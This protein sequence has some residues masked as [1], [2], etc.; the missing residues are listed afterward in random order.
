MGLHIDIAREYIRVFVCVP[1]LCLTRNLF[2]IVDGLIPNEIDKLWKAPGKPVHEQA[3][4]SIRHRS[5]FQDL[6]PVTEQWSPARDR[7]GHGSDRDEPYKSSDRPRNLS[8]SI[9]DYRYFTT[10][11]FW[12]Y[13]SF[14]LT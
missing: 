9:K 6:T 4:A 2:P 13:I 8:S 11:P 7:H 14:F 10:K 5:F 1:A 3:T 12:Y